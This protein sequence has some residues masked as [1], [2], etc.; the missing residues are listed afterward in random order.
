MT[1]LQK[2]AR[3]RE[4]ENELLWN[5]D[6]RRNDGKINLE[7]LECIGVLWETPTKSRWTANG[8]SVDN[9]QKKKSLSFHQSLK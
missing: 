5:V 1:L 9:S 8:A 6:K 2:D 7:G 4:V 3:E